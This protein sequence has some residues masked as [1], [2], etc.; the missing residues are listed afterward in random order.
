MRARR[1]RELVHAVV[2][3]RVSFLSRLD[4]PRAK[5][6]E[7]SVLEKSGGTL[8]ACREDEVVISL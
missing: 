6:C 3:K 1:T 2:E 4:R 7:Q 5:K 8:D